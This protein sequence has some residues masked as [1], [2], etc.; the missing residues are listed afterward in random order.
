MDGK[1][2]NQ[3]RTRYSRVEP[4]DVGYSERL[5]QAQRLLEHAR[6]AGDI[7]ALRRLVRREPH[8]SDVEE[9]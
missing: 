7:E 5:A 4:G 2:E 9:I 8:A 1:R 6:S 3:G